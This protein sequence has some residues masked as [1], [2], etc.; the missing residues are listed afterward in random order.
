MLYDYSSDHNIT[1]ERLLSLSSL[2]DTTSC[3]QYWRWMIY[4]IVCKKIVSKITK[5]SPSL[6]FYPLPKFVP[7]LLARGVTSLNK[8]L[9]KRKKIVDCTYFNRRQ[10]HKNCGEV[11]VFINLKHKKTWLF[12][13]LEMGIRLFFL[14]VLDAAL[15]F[16]RLMRVGWHSDFGNLPN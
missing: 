6:L 1:F 13:C 15:L 10:R 4:F 12:N 9:Q 11:G 14:I 7:P 8:I 5:F 2:Y 16:S 3:W